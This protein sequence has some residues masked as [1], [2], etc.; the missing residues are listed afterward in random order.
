MTGWCKYRVMLSSILLMPRLFALPLTNP[1]IVLQSVSGNGQC[2][3]G[4]IV[5]VCYHVYCAILQQQTDDKTRQTAA[6]FSYTTL[7][8][9]ITLLKNITWHQHANGRCC[10]L[11]SFVFCC[12][13]EIQT[14]LY[15][16]SSFKTVFA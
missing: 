6:L 11:Q 8:F 13:F 14:L 9:V 7:H 1:S 4:F 10:R 15:P 5:T 2:G 12:A 16:F 3:E